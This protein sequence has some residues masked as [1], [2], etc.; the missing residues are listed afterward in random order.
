MGSKIAKRPP[1]YRTS[2]TVLE[3]VGVWPGP[4]KR[5]LSRVESAPYE[6][7]VSWLY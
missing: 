7:Q 4:L 3:I 6:E 5:A 2:G 1:K